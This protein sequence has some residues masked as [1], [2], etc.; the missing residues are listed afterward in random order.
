MLIDSFYTAVLNAL[1]KNQMGK[2]NPSEYESFLHK[3]LEKNYAELFSDFKKV[4][5]KNM[6][7]QQ[8]TNYGNESFN[9]KQALEH[10]VA[11]KEITFSSGSVVIPN[12]V[13]V[14]NAL[15]DVGV[16]YEKVDLAM[17]NR[18]TKS[19]ILLP[20][21]CCPIYSIQGILLKIYPV[22]DKLILDYFRKL[23]PPKY[24]YIVDGGVPLFN[25]N[26]SDFQDIDIHP[27]MIPQLF[28]DVLQLCGINLQLGEV[29][30][31]VSQIKQEQMVNTQ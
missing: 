14:V 18:L 28:I 13:Y 20:T 4:D 3:A 27:M 25:P 10:Y 23:K 22:K 12:D 11:E 31:F 5:Y 2:I 7:F 26:A 19:P 21:T 8:T 24:T 30:Q 1:N 17:F 16:E 29:N 15:W 9:R 6:R